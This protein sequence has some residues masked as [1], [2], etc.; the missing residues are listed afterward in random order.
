MGMKI[1]VAV[2]GGVDSV[3]LL[4]WL[5]RQQKHDLVVAHFDHG[6]RQESADDARFVAGLARKYDLPFEVRREELGV[7]ASEDLAR[8][9]RYVFLYEV[10]KKHQA[11]IATAHHLDDLVET[12][13]INLLRGSRWRGLA[14]MNSQQIWR[15]L[16]NKT[17]RELVEY[18]LEHRLEWCDDKTNWQ[19]RYLRN[20]L[21]RLLTEMD[22][23]TK[24][25]IYNLWQ[26]QVALRQEIEREIRLADFPIFSRYFLIMIAEEVARELIYYQILQDQKASLL[27]RQLN[28]ALLAIKTGQIGKQYQVGQG[29]AVKLQKTNWRAEKL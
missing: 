14:S 4:D 15:P 5:M 18:A 22:D 13:A 7:K 6:I 3:V 21:R 12:I 23:S 19:N 10:A 16:L 11:K 26:K 2:S 29:V 17:K 28:H 24:R 9:R 20:R 27:N 25:Q 8:K 1:V